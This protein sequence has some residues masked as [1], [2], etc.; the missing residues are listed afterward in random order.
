MTQTILIILGLTIILLLIKK[1]K[2]V[3]KVCATVWNETLQKNQNKEKILNLLRGKGQLSNHDI[4]MVLEVSERSIVR[5][6]DELEKE[7]RVAQVG[8]TGRGVIYR[9]R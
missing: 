5:Y 4:R 3:V 1:S 7:G 6:M 2:D 9:I 8:T